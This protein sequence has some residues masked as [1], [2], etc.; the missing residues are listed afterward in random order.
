MARYVIT[1]E[2]NPGLMLESLTLESWFEMYTTENTWTIEP[3]LAMHF[4][5]EEAQAVIE[6]I[7]NVIDQELGEQLKAQT[8]ES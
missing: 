3:I 7:T 6:F 2:D 1:R 5:K 4:N 8:I